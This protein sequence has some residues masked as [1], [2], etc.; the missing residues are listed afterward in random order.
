MGAEATMSNTENGKY[1]FG[2]IL[3]R[4]LGVSLGVELAPPKICNMN[5]VYCECGKTTK[6]TSEIDNYVPAETIISELDNYL[7]NDPPHIDIITLAGSGEPTLNAGLSDIIAHVRTQYPQYKIGILTNS[8]T[9]K[10]KE[11][12]EKIKDLDY[13]LPSIDAMIESSFRKIT[14][15]ARKDSCQDV[16][17]GLRAFSK[18]FNG[19]LWIEVFI[20][21]GIND[22][23][24]ELTLFKEFFEEIK[25]TRVQINSIDR[26]GTCSWV[27]A[28]SLERLQEIEQFLHP[29][30]VEIISRK[31]KTMV[32]PKPSPKDREHILL[33]IKRRPLTIEDLSVSLG[34]SIN[35][36]TAFTEEL[37]ADGEV[38]FHTVNDRKFL[39]VID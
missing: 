27:E 33:T 17:D 2:P 37:I 26:P 8:L 25:P 39:K 28:P 3:S 10:Q 12:R 15:S 35:E 16:I 23:E 36:A 7:Q 22:T 19:N 11:I 30:P 32:I 14:R 29:L 13:V 18:E 5:C 34:I 38:E 9:L 1:L 6:L 21:P 4:R 31:A 24:E 20:I